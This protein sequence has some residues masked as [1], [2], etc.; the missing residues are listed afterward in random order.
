[1]DEIPVFVTIFFVPEGV[2]EAD[3]ED[4][5]CSDCFAPFAG[6]LEDILPAALRC[7]RHSEGVGFSGD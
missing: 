5:S 3:K 1:M 2:Q 7:D 4:G 6:A